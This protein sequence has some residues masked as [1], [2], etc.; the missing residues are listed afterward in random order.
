MIHKLQLRNCNE[1]LLLDDFDFKRVRN[2][3]WYLF[4]RNG[5][6]YASAQ[7]RLLNNEILKPLTFSQIAKIRRPKKGRRFLKENIYFED[8][9]LITVF[10]HRF[11]L[12]APKGL[13][14]D[15]IN[16]NGLDNR[17]KNIR[18]CTKKENM[19]NRRISINNTSGYKGVYYHKSDKRKKRWTVFIRTDDNRKFIGRFLTALDAAKAY[20]EAATKYHG[21]F[22]RLNTL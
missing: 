22:A 10:L 14:V 20:N 19:Q 13:E 15:H 9:P 3:K 21:E 7:V 18:L 12:N 6:K 16:G 11:I 4:N 5:Y 8:Q 17:R 2:A 1:F